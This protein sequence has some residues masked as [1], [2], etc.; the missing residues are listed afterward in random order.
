MSKL[1]VIPFEK[2]S[3][4]M[5]KSG[6]HWVRRKSSHNTFCNR[7]GKVIVIPDHGKKVITR[8]LLRKI[9]RDAELSIE[10]YTNLLEEI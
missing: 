6:F 2:L 5:E 1:P 3:K 4:I 10:E 7:N 8:P 9:L